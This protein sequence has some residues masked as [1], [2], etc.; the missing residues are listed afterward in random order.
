METQ[1]MRGIVTPDVP[2][3]RSCVNVTDSVLPMIH[4]GEVVAFHP[5]TAR[6]AHEVGMQPV[7]GLAEVWAQAM[8]LPGVFGYQ[9]D[10]VEEQNSSALT[11]KLELPLRITA[12]RHQ[13]KRTVLPAT[14]NV[15]EV[16]AGEHV[17]GVVQHFGREPT[18]EIL[19]SRSEFKR[20]SLA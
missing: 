19:A 20:V 2:K 12:E 5:A 15:G 9:R 3:R 17:A 8:P 10:H 4:V 14:A 18:L 7:K 6:K 13:V 1:A 16:A 11:R